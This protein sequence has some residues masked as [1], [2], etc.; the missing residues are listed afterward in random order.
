MAQ[1]ETGEKGIEADRSEGKIVDTMVVGEHGS[2]IGVARI[3]TTDGAVNDP[4]VW[5]RILGHCQIPGLVGFND[6]IVYVP[7]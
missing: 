4:V 7:E 2:C 1:V 5:A 6:E 3:P